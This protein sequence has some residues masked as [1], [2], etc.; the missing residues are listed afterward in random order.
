MK[1][2]LA[3]MVL[4]SGEVADAGYDSPWVHKNRLWRRSLG[5]LIMQ[6]Q[7][8]VSLT[9]GPFYVISYETMLSVRNVPVSCALVGR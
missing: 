3:V 1:A 9:G 8:P 2:T 6:A 4:Q 7:K 5:L